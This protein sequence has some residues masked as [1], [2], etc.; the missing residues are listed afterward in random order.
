MN[1]T[2]SGQT[3]RQLRFIEELLDENVLI[4]GDVAEI[5]THTWAIHGVIPVGGDVI[6][7]E[8]DTYSEARV[9]LDTISTNGQE[10]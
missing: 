9:V 7:A 2:R 6:V 5:G 3:D 8:F 4:A 1:E 10:Q